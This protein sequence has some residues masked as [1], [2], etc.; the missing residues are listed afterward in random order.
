MI[1]S[2]SQRKFI[3]PLILAAGIAVLLS[4]NDRDP[5]HHRESSERLEHNFYEYLGGVANHTYLIPYVYR[6]LIPTSITFIHHV[7]PSVDGLTIDFIFKVILLWLCQITFF[8][9]QRFFF[10]PAES[11]LGVVLLDVLLGFS[12]VQMQGPTLIETTDILNLL[13][14]VLA[15]I[16]IYLKHFKS[17]CIILILGTLNRETTLFLP[18][19]FLVVNGINRKSF[20]QTF[21]ALLAVAIP[22]FALHLLIHPPIANWVMFDAINQNIPLI[23]KT[24]IFGVLMANIH[25]LVL[26]GPLTL[27]ALYKFPNHPVFL[28]SVSFIA[29]PFV[30][31]HYIVGAIMEARLWMPMYIILIPLAVDTLVKLFQEETSNQNILI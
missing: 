7:A 27:V 31:L 6:I 14:F 12:L 15:F 25:L 8:Y 18:L 30:V 17:F 2:L 13:V 26:L 16:M 21:I 28:K 19:A 20:Y 9:Y 22:Y 29:P 1:K 10:K 3:F 23:D 4:L 24:K 11:F 5:I